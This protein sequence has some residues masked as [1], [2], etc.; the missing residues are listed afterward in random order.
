MKNECTPGHHFDI[1]RGT[2]F[3]SWITQINRRLL[4]LCTSQRLDGETLILQTDGC[5]VF[6]II[7]QESQEIWPTNCARNYKKHAM[8]SFLTSD[9]ISEWFYIPSNVWYPCPPKHR[10]I[11]WCLKCMYVF[12]GFI[13]DLTHV[14]QP[15]PIPSH[16]YNPASLPL[17]FFSW[18]SW[19]F[20]RQTP[21]MLW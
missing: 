9:M 5:L 11:L 21:V 14:N 17:N 15:I 19:S 8:A 12:L 6:D 2:L 4:T 16:H 1:W 7:V 3:C 18:I 20:R 13:W 10:Y